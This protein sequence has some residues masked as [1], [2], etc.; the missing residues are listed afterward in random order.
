MG[1][2]EGCFEYV[3]NRRMLFSCFFLSFF[4]PLLF[5]LFSSS[6]L[7]LRLI[8]VLEAWVSMGEYEE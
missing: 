3:Y 2:F 6:A 1:G 8:P 5:L 7:C 4:P